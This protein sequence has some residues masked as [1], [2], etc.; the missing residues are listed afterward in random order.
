CVASINGCTPAAA[1]D[2][3]AE[4]AT[5]VTFSG[6]SYNPKCIKVKAGTVVT[7]SGN[8]TNHPLQGGVVNGA[9]VPAASGPFVPV[10]NS[11]NTKD[12]TLSTPGTYPFY[13]VPHATLG[14]NG[15]VFV[16]P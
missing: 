8:F 11:G 9:A 4:T 6:L 14:M 7:F 13:C 12:F 3:T 2:L 5:T 16:V 10:T 1:V 15:A